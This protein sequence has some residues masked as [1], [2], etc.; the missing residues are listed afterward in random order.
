MSLF[1][2]NVTQ[3]KYNSY[4]GLFIYVRITTI[5][6]VNKIYFGVLNTLDFTVSQSIRVIGMPFYQFIA[7]Q[8]EFKCH[9]NNSF[10]VQTLNYIST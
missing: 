10:I 8:T 4:Y 6:I 5:N 1:N 9:L 3:K 7:W 2:T